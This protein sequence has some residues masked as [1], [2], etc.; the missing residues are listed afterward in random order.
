MLKKNSGLKILG[1]LAQEAPLTIYALARKSGVAVSLVHK[2]VKNPETGLEPQKIVRV[3]S[4]GTWRTGLRRVEYVLTFRGLVE[5]FSLLV[6]E[7][8]VKRPEVNS[9][10]RRYREFCDYSVFTEQ[11]YLEAWLGPQVYDLICSTA[12]ILKNRPPSVPII[13]ESVSGSLPAIIQSINEQ[14]IPIPIQ[15]EE[16]T[17]PYVFALV[18]FDFV[19][20]ATKG[21][22]TSASPNPVL[23][24]LVNET[25]EALRD[26]LEQQ[27]KEVEK[28]EDALKKQLS[29]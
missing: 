17:L 5:Y 3:T 12:W 22:K 13:T 29:T 7:K 14:R 6:E 18:F 24:K 28:F 26:A 20:L 2:I 19:A 21:E 9:V 15:W 8:L 11:E 4:E 1:T 10:I 27:I 25:Y 23:Y 16:K